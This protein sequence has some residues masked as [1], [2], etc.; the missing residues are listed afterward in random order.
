MP[1]KEE[2]KVQIGDLLFEIVKL[3]CFFDINA[4]IALTKSVEKFINRF[5]YIENSTFTQEK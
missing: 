4:E 1:K 5:R 2:F 3:S